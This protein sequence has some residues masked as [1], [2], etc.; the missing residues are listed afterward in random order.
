[1]RLRNNP[2][3]N[4]DSYKFSHPDMLPPGIE[5]I[6]SYIEARGGWFPHTL[7]FGLQAF[8]QDY[9]MEPITLDDIDEATELLPAHNMPFNRNS[10]LTILNDHNGRIPIQIDAVEEGHVIPVSNS[11]VRVRSTD[12]RF[13]ALGNHFETPTLRGVWYPTTVATLSFEAKR[14]IKRFLDDT[15]DDPAGQLPYKL[16]DMGARG[17]STDESAMIGGMG[18]L[19]NFRGTDTL[20]AIRGARHHYQC[21]MA[22]INI[23]AAE[24]MA[25]TSWGRDHEVDAYR[26]VLNH[27]AERGKMIAVVSDSYDIFHAV[28][29]LWGEQLKDQVLASGATVVI[30][31]DSGDPKS[32]VPILLS[33]LAKNFG[34][35]LNSK[36]YEVI[37]PAVRVIHSDGMNLETI[38]ALL[39]RLKETKWSAD[40]ITFGMG[41]GLLQK[42]DRDTQKW[43]MKASAAKFNGLWR[44]VFKDPVTDP[45]KR[46]KR[47]VLALV[48]DEAGYRTVPCADAHKFGG[49]LLTPVYRDGKLLRKTTFDEVRARS[50]EALLGL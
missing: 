13:P 22:G 4:T 48:K 16:H 43:A 6:S 41:G 46:S 28:D 39:A 40:N 35:Q 17:V 18:H 15:S 42:V 38:E 33:S 5:E 44:D 34:S 31:P 12:R 7:F 9:L 8:I 10:W 19:V 45:G 24:H 3:L 23:P 11:L 14:I 2:I 47:G 27:F 30:R 49:D 26:N 50:E 32:V 1:M 36:G 29:K 25:I 21:H 20:A 37:N